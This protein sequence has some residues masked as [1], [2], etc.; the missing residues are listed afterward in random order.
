MLTDDTTPTT[1]TPTTPRA[2]R[3]TATPA[4]PLPTTEVEELPAVERAAL[5]AAP[6]PIRAMALEVWRT[7]PAGVPADDTARWGVDVSRRTWF[8]WRDAGRVTLALVGHRAMVPKLE[9][10]RALLGMSAA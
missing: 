4:A 5:D 10:V 7:A 6:G 2:R 8:R 1:P 9:L 3:R